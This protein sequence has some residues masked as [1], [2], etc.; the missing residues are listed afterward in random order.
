[1]KFL[2]LIAALLACAASWAQSPQDTAAE[3]SR[4]AAERGRAEARYEAEQKVCWQKFAVNDCLASA[5]A[6][7]REVLSDLRRQELSISDAERK[8]RGV[9]RKR[10]IE[11]K[12]SEQKQEQSSAERA[13]AAQGQAGKEQKAAQKAA[14]R[15]EAEAAQ[16]AQAAQ[17]QLQARERAAADRAARERKAA[18]AADELARSKERQKDAQ[19]RRAR[20]ARKLAEPQKPDVK[21]LP[22]PP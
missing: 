2:F 19:E 6:R 21:P 13:R 17:R 7:R 16:K 14:E 9:E 12:A 5:K 20:V 18:Q 22:V 3:Q 15:P 1:M 8:R 11:E 4:I 10:A